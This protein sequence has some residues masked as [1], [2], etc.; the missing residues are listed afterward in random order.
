[1]DGFKTLVVTLGFH[2]LIDL[3]DPTLGFQNRH[4]ALPVDGL[5]LGVRRSEKASG[6][7]LDDVGS[8]LWPEPVRIEC[9]V[10]ETVR[11]VPIG[12]DDLNF[13]ILDHLAMRL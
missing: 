7:S 13:Q 11:L 10:Q 6:I 12:S 4:D 1:M 2:A 3:I 5:V 9:V 8:I